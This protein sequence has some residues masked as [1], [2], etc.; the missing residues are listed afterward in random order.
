MAIRLAPESIP[1]FLAGAVSLTRKHRLALALLDAARELAR[2]AGASVW[3]FAI[4]ITSLITE[5][6]SVNDLPRLVTQGYIEH[7]IE[8]TQPDD[9]SRT[10][11]RSRN[12]GFCMRTCFVL[13]DDGGRLLAE[14]GEGGT[15]RTLGGAAT[16]RDKRRSRGTFACLGRSTANTSRR[17]AHR[18]MVSCAIA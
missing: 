18:E 12:L 16:N 7:A 13:S 15:F 8:L 6:I 1:D 17:R 14:F 11:Q 9:A 3:D 5:G 2:E 4:E 10:F